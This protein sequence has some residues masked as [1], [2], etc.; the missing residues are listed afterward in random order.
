[1]EHLLRDDLKLRLEGFVK[2]YSDY[3]ASVSRPYLVLA[4]TGGGF[5][6][7]EENFAS[8]GL[9]HLVSRGTGTAYGIEFLAQK[10]MSE[11]P[12]Y[13]LLS[14]TWARTR[15]TAL[16]GI[17]RPGAFDQRVLANLSGGY[18]LNQRWEASMRFR[19]GTGRPYTPFNADGTQNVGSLYASRLKDFH[20]LD[21]RVDRYWN[22]ERWSLIVYVDVQNVYNNKYSG[23]VRWN[24]REGKVEEAE[25]SIG[26]L[27]SVGVSAEF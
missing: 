27:P 2:R 4:N 5:G 23:V 16:D 9:E 14:L 19:F 12:L 26:I 17:T 11:I 15:F 22:F 25:N 18:R 10:K 6:G 7:A 24:A 21:L 8:F 1:V 20:A 3:P 13:G